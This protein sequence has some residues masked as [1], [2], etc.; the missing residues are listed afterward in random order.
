MRKRRSKKDSLLLYMLM[1]IMYD[2]CFGIRDEEKT[3]QKQE[4]RGKGSAKAIDSI[5]R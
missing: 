4:Q 1:I 2:G 3:Q 5:L